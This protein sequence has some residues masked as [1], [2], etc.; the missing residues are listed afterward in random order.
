VFGRIRGAVGRG[1]FGGADVPAALVYGDSYFRSLRALAKAEQT[2]VKLAVQDFIERPDAPGLRLHKL[3]NGLWSISPNMDLRVIVARDGG[4]FALLHVDH[5]DR[6]HRWAE[7]RA[8]ERHETTG[9]AQIVEILEVTREA[10][11]VRPRP[12]KAP[13]P[14]L[15]GES[16]GYLLSLGV[17]RL[18][19]GPLK[20][21][22]DQ[23]ALLD[24][25][26][27][28]PVEAAERLVLLVSGERPEPA[29]KAPDGADP[30]ATPDARRRFW[31]AADEDALQRALERPWQEW[32]VFLH[33]A[34]REAAER[35]WSGPAR[36]TGPAGT[37]KSVVAMH[38]A[39]RLAR[40]AGGAKVLLTTHTDALAARLSQGMDAL[41]GEGTA[42]RGRVAVGTIHG[43]AARL[44]AAA[45]RKVALADE[46]RIAA[47][48]AAQC[49]GLDGAG[50]AAR[51]LLNEWRAVID[52]W[53]VRQWETYR[54]IRR[55]GRGA[56]L[57]ERRRAEIWPVFAAVRE[58]L[59]AA[60]LMTPGDLCEA[61]DALLQ[62]GGQPP[63]YAHVVVDEAQDLGPRELI[64]ACAL[65][66]EGPRGLF[67]AGD[68][69]Q[70]VMR[71]P[72]SWLAAGVDVRGRS[73]RL[74]VNYRTSRQIRR[75][76]DG[77]LP[78]TLEAIGGGAEGR[79]AVSLLSGPPPEVVG[80]ADAAA[81]AD[82][83]RGWIAAHL[84]RGVPP[85]EIAVLARRDEDLG[86]ILRP[87]M[88]ATGLVMAPIGDI[89]PAA[90]A[91]Y[92]GAIAS[93]KG[94]EFRAVALV[95]V[96][97]SVLPLADALAAEESEEGRALA[98]QRERHLLYVG[99]TRAR[100]SLLVTHGPRP[101]RFLKA[102]DTGDGRH[103]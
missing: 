12:P 21:A 28:L 91:L 98:L 36:V 24:L 66:A 67:F 81:Q 50:G 60:G 93:A 88:Q 102:M 80:C 84:A 47:L 68:G 15:A 59:D 23:D 37:G 100:E 56:A 39:A 22:P 53:G 33:P 71:H 96:D 3:R 9:S 4:T 18:W 90:G 48:I 10:A 43:E 92:A 101:S 87:A 83:L 38:R 1:A 42:A 94:L 95:G 29:P 63:P 51:F 73:R 61:A 41:L 46:A 7:R 31:L 99:C 64:L 11:A 54:D 79:G 57:G 26:D 49:G 82:V 62:E 85:G 19:L 86:P 97:E 14:P 77:A 69:G 44:L 52:H 16:D 17:P 34:Q 65:A 76:S 25:M 103:G 8:Y 30:F 32:L 72:F 78:A 13:P 55:L 45:G 74:A 27:R 35:D 2:T 70:Q 5:H 6:A 75:F 89:A 40:A 20:A 58:A